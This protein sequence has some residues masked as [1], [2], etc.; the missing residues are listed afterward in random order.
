MGSKNRKSL[1]RAA[2]LIV[3]VS[4]L[5]LIT[6]CTP[7]PTSVPTPT[8]PPRLTFVEAPPVLCQAAT[9][10]RLVPLVS[11][12]WP[13]DTKAA[14]SLVATGANTDLGHGEW[15][16]ATG[17][18]LVAFPDGKAL[19]P[20]E[21]HIALQLESNTLADHTFTVGEDAT[22]V[23]ALALAMSPGGPEI[24]KLEE[25]TSHFY[26]RYSYR[27]ACLGTPYWIAVY[28]DAENICKH[29]ATLPQESGTAAIACYRQDGAPLQNGPYRAEFTLM[30]E[31]QQ[32]LA[33][34]VGVPPVTPT[35]V[36]S[37]TPTPSPTP[38]PVPVC[39]S[40]FTAAGLTPKGDP[41]LP[42]E[43]FEW[44]SQVI[45]TGARCVNLRAGAVWQTQW[46]RNGQPVRTAEGV[47][48][49]A[50]EGVVWDSITGEP[51][52]PFLLPGTYTITLT[53]DDVAPLTAEFRLIAY[54]KPQ[55]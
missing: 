42:Q 20:G 13:A 41:F 54:V 21:Y 2:F 38:Q 3:A 17:E 11:G 33:F 1:L 19:P 53:L 52:A 45:Y 15:Q 37:A 51:R 4:V 43:R 47:W 40:M 16:P 46:Y 24:L 23:T 29:N 12:E 31:V 14:W 44:Y 55:P 7:A 30:G 32:R 25:A 50:A 27:G 8:P 22:T 48:Q 36:P 35:P 5:G 34:E 28:R 6:A 49:G 10:I 26:L 39:D 9:Q 18:L